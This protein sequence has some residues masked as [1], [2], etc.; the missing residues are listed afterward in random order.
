MRLRC[1]HAA[2]YEEGDSKLT[3]E[4]RFRVHIPCA[5]RQHLLVPLITRKSYSHLWYNAC[6]HGT[7]TF[8]QSE[9][10]LALNNLLSCGEET[11]FRSLSLQ[12]ISQIQVVY[13]VA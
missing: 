1:I 9:S 11:S 4:R 12:L 5:V 2:L 7:Q 8:V 3:H 10:S 6:E 13:Y